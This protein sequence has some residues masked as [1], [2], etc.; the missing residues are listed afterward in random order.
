MEEIFRLKLIM[1]LYIG[2]MVPLL[3]FCVYHLFK[4]NKKDECP[5]HFSASPTLIHNWHE[6]QRK[7]KIRKKISSM[8]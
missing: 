5:Y 2:A 1:W 4:S 8:C 3:L 7:L 6:E